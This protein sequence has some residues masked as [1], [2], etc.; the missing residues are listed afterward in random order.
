M[1]LAQITDVH[2]GFDPDDPNELNRQRLDKVLGALCA[3]NPQPDML[4]ITGDLT[5]KGTA[6]SYAALQEA[7]VPCPFPVHMC[8]GNHDARGAFLDAFP[9]VPTADGFVQYEL[10]VGPL[11]LLVL[12]TLEE[13][14]HGGAFCTVRADWLRARLQERRDIPT[15]LVLHHPPLASGI[16]WMTTDPREPWVGRLQAA[17]AG[18]DNII[19]LIAGHIHRH[20]A[21]NWSGRNLSV[22]ASTAPHVALDF[23]VIDPDH[24]DGRDMVVANEP[25]FALHWWNGDQLISHFDTAKVGDVMAVYDDMMQPLVRHLLS[26]RPD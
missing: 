13:G 17:I 18:H 24:P 15:L 8:L 5:D 6:E 22:C 16:D 2:L 7:I 20:F 9:D 21:A 25:G 4:L 26:E 3:I 14:R 11:R 1:L 23:S 10:D 19:G 12:D